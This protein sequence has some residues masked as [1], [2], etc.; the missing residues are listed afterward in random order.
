MWDFVRFED[1]ST[2]TVQYCCDM[3]TRVRAGD[4]ETWEIW[5]AAR[6][7]LSYV[8]LTRVAGTGAGHRRRDG[9]KGGFRFAQ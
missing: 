1:V 7:I 5:C 4:V 9:C 3:S 8:L 6:I 2:C